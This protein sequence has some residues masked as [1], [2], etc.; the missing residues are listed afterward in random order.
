MKTFKLVSLITHVSLVVLANPNGPP[1]RAAAAHLLRPECEGRTLNK[2]AEIKKMSSLYP[3]F[4]SFGLCYKMSH[5]RLTPRTQLLDTSTK[6]QR[7]LARP[8]PSL[9]LRVSVVWPG[10]KNEPCRSST[11][12]S[13][14]SME[15]TES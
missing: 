5:V 1:P 15:C 3:L 11:R 14:I 2:K 7:H 13:L 6:A 12:L 9:R 8:A 4:L 10:T